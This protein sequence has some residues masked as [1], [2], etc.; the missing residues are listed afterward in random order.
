[1]SNIIEV[2]N[3]SFSY[4]KHTIIEDLSFSVSKGEFLA[5]AGPNGAGKTTLLNLICGLLKPDTGTITIDSANIKSYSAKKLAQKI[6]VV[7]QEFIPAF[8]F[9]AGEIV[10]MG[11]SPYLSSIGFETKNDLEAVTE[12]MEITD[13]AKFTDRPLKN[14]SGGERQRVLIARALAQQTPIIL[15]DEPTSFLDF[16]HQVD[17]Y[18]LLKNSQTQNNK[19]IIAVTHDINLAMQYCDKAMLGGFDQ[20]CCFGD[21]KNVFSKDRIEAVFGTKVFQGSLGGEKFFLPLGQFSKIS[22]TDT[23]TA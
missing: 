17:I 21:T 5:I 14:L 13:T 16:K 6:S 3:L 7:R 2:K 19:T 22:S 10:A 12:A 4:Q 20:K 18:D 9:T 23:G 1:M 15:L 8:D 11:R